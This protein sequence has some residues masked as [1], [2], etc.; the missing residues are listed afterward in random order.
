MKKLQSDK[1]R[2][3]EKN[4]KLAKE[5]ADLTDSI[6]SNRIVKDLRERLSDEKDRYVMFIDAFFFFSCFHIP[7]VI[8]SQLAC[9]LFLVLL[10]VFQK[11]VITDILGTDNWSWNWKGSS[12]QPRSS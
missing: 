12:W 1:K 8:L 9:L 10:S 2:V 6:N 3:D 11:I 7:I 5:L 4:K